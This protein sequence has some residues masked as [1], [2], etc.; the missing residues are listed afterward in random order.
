MVYLLESLVMALVSLTFSLCLKP[1][2][3]RSVAHHRELIEP[4]KARESVRAAAVMKGHARTACHVAAA[5]CAEPAEE[6]RGWNK[7]SSKLQYWPWRVA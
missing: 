1:G 3:T 6:P 2:F 4:F 5:S 7:L